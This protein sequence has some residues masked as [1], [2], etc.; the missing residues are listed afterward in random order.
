MIKPIGRQNLS[1]KSYRFGKT[2]RMIKP[3]GRQNLS[4]KTYRLGKTY[5]MIKP[6]GRQ[7][8]SAA[9][10]KPVGGQE[11]YIIYVSSFKIGSFHTISSAGIGKPL[12]FS[13]REERLR[14]W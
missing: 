4:E 13:Q 10:T 7:N 2:Y 14:V 5:R 9:W 8:L 12:P 6:I 3:I 1:E 11:K